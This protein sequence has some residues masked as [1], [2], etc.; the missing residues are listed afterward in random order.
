M[1][2]GAMHLVTILLPLDRR[3]GAPQP[4]ALFGEVRAELAQR[5]GGAT[6]FTRAAAEGVWEDGG[7]ID[8]D[9]IVLVEV[10]AETLERGWW[11]QYR[12]RLETAFGQDEVL[13]R[14]SAAERL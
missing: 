1:R 11:A 3:D 14:A 4:A 9:R 13:I 5:F 7:A 2:W 12:R 10:V 8:E 6:F